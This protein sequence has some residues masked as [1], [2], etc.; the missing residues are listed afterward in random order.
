MVSGV[1]LS[2]KHVFSVVV[3]WEGVDGE[4]KFFDV[5]KMWRE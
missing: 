2:S 5:P 4:G 3:L 1:D